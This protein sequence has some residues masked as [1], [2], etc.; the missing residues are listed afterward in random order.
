M[1]L[2]IVLQVNN[3][4]IFPGR[5]LNRSPHRSARAV[6]FQ[7]SVRLH[8][9]EKI[10]GQKIVT[11]RVPDTPSPNSN[12]NGVGAGTPRLFDVQRDSRKE[13]VLLVR[14]TCGS[15]LDLTICLVV[16]LVLL[17]SVFILLLSTDNVVSRRIDERFMFRNNPQLLGCR[18]CRP[19]SSTSADRSTYHYCCETDQVPTS[20]DKVY[21]YSLAKRLC[22][23]RGYIDGRFAFLVTYLLDI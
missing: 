22:R 23:Y 16:L 6:H 13:Q 11:A 4:I 18:R 5:L 9:D 1:C 12:L 17:V 21:A 20:V 19:D 8:I 3:Q 15:K 10:M 2:E 14:R 7:Q